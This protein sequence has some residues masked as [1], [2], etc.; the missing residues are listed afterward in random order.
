[1]DPISL[2]LLIGG[3]GSVISGIFGSSSADKAAKAQE[4]AANKALALQEKT[5]AQARTDALPWMDAG[6]KALTQYQGELGMGGPDFQSQFTKTPGYD[7]Q[8]NEA[9]K[10]ATNNL[11]AL[12]MKNSGAALKALTKLRS[13]LAS[14]EYGNYLNR[15]SGLAGTGQNAQQTL[16]NQELNSSNNQSQTIQD[17]GAA[18]ASGYVGSANAWTNAIGNFANNAGSTLGN[19]DQNWKPIVRAA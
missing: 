12:G 1:M 18:R 4:R 9:E 17:A 8:V 19:Y 3:A 14:Q 7:F 10:G 11:A 15:V 13:G 16:S 2:S 5:I 6:R